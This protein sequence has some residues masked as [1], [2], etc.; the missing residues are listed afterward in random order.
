MLAKAIPIIYA[1]QILDEFPKVLKVYKEVS[2]V[3]VPLKCKLTCEYAPVYMARSYNYK[4]GP[5]NSDAGIGIFAY[6][7]E[8]QE[9]IPYNRIAWSPVTV[10][11]CYTMKEDI[12]CIGK[13]ADGHLTVT[14]N[15]LYMP[16]YP[17]KEADYPLEQAE[18][19]SEHLCEKIESLLVK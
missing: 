19:L 2:I 6:L 16:E 13:E 7:K 3:S 18:Y 15:R 1:K 9:A 10:L 14:T 8:K 12:T 11:T 4:K 17:N 5:N